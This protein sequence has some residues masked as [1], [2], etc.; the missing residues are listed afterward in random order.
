MTACIDH[1]AGRMHAGGA[2]HQPEIV[3]HVPSD[4]LQ[5]VLAEAW[6]WELLEAC[7]AAV[8]GA[9]HWRMEMQALLRAIADCEVPKPPPEHLR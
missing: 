9:A 7:K 2:A 3:R 1:A 6:A 5:E 4:R 8:A